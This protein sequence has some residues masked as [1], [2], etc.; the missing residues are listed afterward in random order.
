M[1]FSIICSAFPTWCRLYFA[2]VRI[3]GDPD[4][5]HILEVAVQ[6]NAMIVTHKIIVTHRR[7]FVGAENAG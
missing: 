1:T 7:D 3:C 5:E 2:S 6:R 4:D